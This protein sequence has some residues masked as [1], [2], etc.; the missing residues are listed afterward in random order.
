[1]T[2]QLVTPETS[3]AV[4]TVTAAIDA[5]P[6]QLFIG[7]HWTPSV[8][9]AT[10]DVVNPAT[11]EVICAVADGSAADGI[12]A[13]EAA[14]AAQR[15]FAA[16]SP[17][18]RAEIL[19][20]A[21]ELLHAQIDR[22][23]LI[24]TYEMGKP[25]AE[26]RDEIAYAAEFFRHF[27]EEAT[28]V[29]GGYQIAPNG[30]SRLLVLKQPV[31]PCLLITPW[32][33]PLAMG[34]R[35]IGPAI[36]AGCTSVVK[37]AQ[38]TPLSMLALAE[39]LV[40][41]G[42]PAG[43][44]NLVTTTDAPGV[45]EPIISSGM[46]RKLS[47]TGST[48]VG[49]V[50]LAQ[51]ATHVMRTSLELGGNAALIVFAD[52]DLDKAVQG[53]LAAKMRNG[54]EACTAANRMYV[55]V[56]VIDE[57][58]H[59]L[60]DAMG[61]L[62]VGNGFDDGVQLGPLIDEAARQK[63]HGLVSDAIDQGATLLTGGEPLERA[64]YFYAPTVL[65]QVPGSARL[66][67]EEIFGPVAP[68]T[69]FSTEAEVVSAANDTEFGLVSY[70]FT[71]DLERALRVAEALETGMVGLNQGIVSNP[72]APFGGVKASGL[73]REGGPTGLDEFLEVKYV[74]IALA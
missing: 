67:R 19:M 43:A 72:A 26:S 6:K 62:A 45:T 64:G 69:S 57:F 60:A 73:G 58:S 29:D 11:G 36:A 40:E 12:R 20:N 38:Q 49:R 9:E 28:R 27:A 65:V 47:F 16:T 14:A 33:F 34:T 44:V 1:M 5:L 18:F 51:C 25:L 52:A 24:M 3:T 8:S 32:N 59:R 61:N 21:F 74:G 56:D 31:G 41:A 70:V 4:E 2:R 42:L 13:I 53:A 37:P 22:L 23:A 10:Y 63:V 35:K 17:R 7:G 46:A 55:H 71:R 66:M 50:L 15:E 48:A 30:G 39:I 68:I 54:G